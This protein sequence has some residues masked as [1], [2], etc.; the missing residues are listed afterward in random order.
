MPPKV[1]PN[2]PLSPEFALKRG[3]LQFVFHEAWKTK[4]AFGPNSIQWDNVQHQFGIIEKLVRAEGET[5]ILL[6]Q[7]YK[8]FKRMQQ[9]ETRV[10]PKNPKAYEDH[11][12]GIQEHVLANAMM[13]ADGTID[14]VKNLTRQ[15]PMPF[16]GKV[17]T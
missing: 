2:A 10:A 12:E 5:L 16:A 11:W 8:A 4:R 3:E 15:D 9:N 7:L 1:I 6:D 13:H 14:V 17:W